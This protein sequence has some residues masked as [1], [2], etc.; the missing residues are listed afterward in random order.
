MDQLFG[1]EGSKLSD[2]ILQH[3]KKRDDDTSKDEE[4]KYIEG[5]I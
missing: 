4:K 3:Y 2:E 5:E 1:D